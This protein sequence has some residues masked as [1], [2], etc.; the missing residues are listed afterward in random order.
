MWDHE[1]HEKSFKKPENKETKGIK[2]KNQYKC[3]D[4]NFQKT[5]RLT[6]HIDY[7]K[8]KLKNLSKIIYLIEK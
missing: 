1:N 7:F 6:A 3:L 5:Y 4:L 8:T 2:F